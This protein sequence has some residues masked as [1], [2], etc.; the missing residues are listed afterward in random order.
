[1]QE[2]NKAR[3]GNESCTA[4]A[5]LSSDKPWTDDDTIKHLKQPVVS[6]KNE[7]DKKGKQSSLHLPMRHPRKRE[8]AKLSSMQ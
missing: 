6:S 7:N 3:E 2:S 8:T 4:K 5:V 1:V